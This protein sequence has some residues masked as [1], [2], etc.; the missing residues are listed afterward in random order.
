VLDHVHTDVTRPG[1]PEWLA[2]E[3]IVQSW[4]LDVMF[5]D[6]Q[7][8]IHAASTSVR[9]MAVESIFR[10]NGMTR[11]MILTKAFHLTK[12]LDRTLSVYHAEL[13]AISDELRDLGYPLSFNLSLVCISATRPWA[14]SFSRRPRP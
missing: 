2:V 8:T 4:L 10:N 6:L 11:A 14:N 9:S 3:A 12:Q 13:K 7:D 5:V 1:D